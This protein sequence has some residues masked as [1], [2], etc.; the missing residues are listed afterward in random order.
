MINFFFPKN[1]YGLIISIALLSKNKNVIFLEKKLF[2][3][4]K[5]L[6]SYLSK[7]LKIKFILIENISQIP[8]FVKNLYINKK[9]LKINFFH[10]ENLRYFK[11]IENLNIDHIF[12]E[13]GIG[14]YFNFINHRYIYGIKNIFN[15]SQKKN[16]Y[17]AYAGVYSKLNHKII[18]DGHKVK[19]II[20][21]D[22]INALKIIKFF[23][24]KDLKTKNLINILQLKNKKVLV[25]VP[26]FLI[27]GDLENFF[28]TLF[29]LKKSKSVFFFKF[30]PQDK[31]IVSKINNIKEIFGKNYFIVNQNMNFIPFEVLVLVA[32]NS[33]IY[34]SI[35]NIPF[36]SS[37]IF[38]NKINLYLPISIKKKYFK[39]NEL[40]KNSYKFYINNFK[41]IEF[42]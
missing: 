28:Q 22:I 6:I 1:F 25:N 35:S 3:K 4:L 32:K 20:P 16:R 7:K 18:I 41:G 40:K 37:L 15:L 26:E 38:S 39:F 31:K 27:S 23:Y 36:V 33:S 19:K 2:L 29:K 9:N 17:T 11:K 12:L 14:N 34:S 5:D 42:I 8:Q 24:K 10:K 13:N 21:K 30:H